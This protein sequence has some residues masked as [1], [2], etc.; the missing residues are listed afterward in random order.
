LRRFLL[1][2]AATATALAVGLPAASARPGAAGGREATPGV[3]ATTIKLGG[4]FPLSGPV[5]AYAPIAVGMDT[6]FKWVNQRKGPDKKVGIYGRKIDFKY[7]DDG[8]NPANA[9]QAANQLVLQDKVFAIV[10]TLGTEVNLAVRPF[11]NQR[12]VPHL[13]V[14]TGASYFGLQYKEFPWTIGWQPDYI[15]TGIAY[16]KWIRANAPNA[17]IAIFYQN[18]DYGKD[19]L[20]GIKIGLAAKRTLIVSELGYEVTD[21]NYASQIS[22]Q[23]ATGADTWVLL[24]TAGA[25]T[26]R[27]LATGKA[28]GFRPETLVI[29]DVAATDGVMRAA[30]ASVGPDYVAGAISSVYLK[31][32]S[33]PRY[34]ND[35]QV[36]KYR[37]ILARFGPSGADPNNTFFYYGMAKAYDTVRLLY[38]A[39]KQP[40]RNSLMAATKKMNW[41]NP[42]A[43]KGVKVKAGP[44]DRFPISQMK[45]QRYTNGS[46]TEFGALIKGR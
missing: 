26:V 39:G 17:K 27:A 40:T 11:L 23:K 6:Y 21:T 34:A 2:S 9:V 36:K 3:T 37:E 46:W 29:N 19:Y 31:S 44:R 42:Y 32:P 28:L 5:S 14:S 41:V 18:D 38:L 12:K 45:L 33:N 15:A 22:R 43:I 30:V 24:T 13:L 1:V 25:P 16:G 7:L 35:A 20:R 10:G 4:S 8:Y